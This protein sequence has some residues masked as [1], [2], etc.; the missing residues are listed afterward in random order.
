MLVDEVALQSF[1]HGAL[2]SRIINR[3]IQG[4]GQGRYTVNNKQM[5]YREF[6]PFIISCEDKR[7]VPAIEY[8]WRCLD[9]DGDGIVSLH[10]LHYFWEE[11]YERMI[12]SRMS[13]PWKFEDFICSLYV[14]LLDGV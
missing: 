4:C 1:E 14:L 5:T 7:T 13:D 12:E 6:I 2:T 3:V 8:W 11:Q 9:L 10:E